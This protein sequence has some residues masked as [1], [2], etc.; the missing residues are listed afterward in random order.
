MSV[1]IIAIGVFILLV[2]LIYF[3]ITIYKSRKRIY[4][5]LRIYK[6]LIVDKKGKFISFKESIN[7]MDIPI[8]KVTIKDKVY[9]F[10][11]DTGASVSY[12]NAEFFMDYAELVTTL[13]LEHSFISISGEKKDTK[14]CTVPFSI[15][16]IKFNEEVFSAINIPYIS[17]EYGNIHLGGILGMDFLRKHKCIIDLDELVIYI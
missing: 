9:P 2:V 1:D 4:R 10:L 12:I 13:E 7:S 6:R 8:I 14:A 17:K 11:I 3:G 15:R 16:G 5:Y